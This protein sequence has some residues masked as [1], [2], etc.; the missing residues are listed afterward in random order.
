MKIIIS[1]TIEMDPEKI[2]PALEKAKPLV[3]GALTQPGCLDYDWCPDP[4]TRGKIRV[5]ERWES[6]KAL[7]DHFN[8]HWYSDMRATL[9]EFGI[10]GADVLKYRIDLAEPVYDETG[11]ARANFFT[12]K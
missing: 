11:V 7:A 5:F 1:G 8:N 4:Y 9:G 10:K 12:E 6:E 2:L 3:D